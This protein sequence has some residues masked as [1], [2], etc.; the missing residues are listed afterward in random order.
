MARMAYAPIEEFNPVS[1]INTTPLIDVMLVLLIMFIITVP[2]STHQ[3]DVDL[4]QTSPEVPPAPPTIHKLDIDSAGRVYWDGVAVPEATLRARLVAMA[5]DPAEPVLH[6]N[7]HDETR[8]ER[9]D[10]VLATVRRAGVT[11]MGFVG[12]SRFEGAF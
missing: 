3:V 2:L 9:F 4:P 6:M 11:R 7:A 1:E 10:E 12:M 8:Y 5:R